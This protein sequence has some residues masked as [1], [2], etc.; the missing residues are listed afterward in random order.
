MLRP[1]LVTILICTCFIGYGQSHVGQ[2]SKLSYTFG[3]LAT[4]GAQDSITISFAM[5]HKASPTKLAVIH[6][7]YGGYY[8]GRIRVADLH[9]FLQDTNIFFVSPAS[10]PKE[11]LTSGAADPTLNGINFVHAR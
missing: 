7:F 9:D 4:A 8:K 1:F 10:V 3:Q 5:G 11:E 2:T 6:S